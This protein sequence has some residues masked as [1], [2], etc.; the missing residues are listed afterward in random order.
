VDG[1]LHLSKSPER[2]LGF[3]QLHEKRNGKKRIEMDRRIRVPVKLS[4]LLR[5]ETTHEALHLLG[6]WSMFRNLLEIS[7]GCFLS[8][9]KY[10]LVTPLSIQVKLEL[11]L[12]VLDDKRVIQDDPGKNNQNAFP[13]RTYVPL[14]AQSSLPSSQKSVML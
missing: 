7:K 8:T 10:L 2:F 11:S 5:L 3:V 14:G 13:E 6:S 1:L 9:V 12:R 4:M